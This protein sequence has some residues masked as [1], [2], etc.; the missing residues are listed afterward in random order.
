MNFEQITLAVG[1]T[2]LR[3]RGAFHPGDQDGVPQLQPGTP[4]GTVVLIGSTGSSAWPA[5]RSEQA[6]GPDPLDT[7]TRAKVEPIAAAAGARAVY[8]GDRPFLPFLRWARRSED[9]HTS[10]LGLLIHPEH[11]LWHSYRA[12]LLLSA[13]IEVPPP[14]ERPSPCT[15]CAQKPCLAACP[16]G[17]FGAGGYDSESCLDHL[18]TAEGRACLNHGCKARNACPVGRTSRYIED[19][20]RFHMRAFAHGSRMRPP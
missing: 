1:A 3:V 20:I 6:P 8:P 16:V 15:S 13:R 12:A 14:T 9:V 4:A 10:P 2:G 17:S 7:W 19:Q 18:A 11:G 5:F